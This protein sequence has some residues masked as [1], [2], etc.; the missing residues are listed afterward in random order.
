MLT[1]KFVKWDARED[2]PAG[3]ES[4][5]FRQAKSVHV[6]YEDDGRTVLQCDDAPDETFEATVGAWE[7]CSYSVAYVMNNA[8]RT[9][10]TIR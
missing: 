6:R 9:V 3:A 4:I 2:R 7:V 1:I 10:D 5:S 8:G